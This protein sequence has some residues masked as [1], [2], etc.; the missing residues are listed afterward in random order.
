MWYLTFG[1]S[2]LNDLVGDFVYAAKHDDGAGRLGGVV[3]EKF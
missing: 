3:Y 2:G 1:D